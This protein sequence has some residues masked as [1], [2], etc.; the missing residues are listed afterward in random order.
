MFVSYVDMGFHL[1]QLIWN[2]SRN[3]ENSLYKHL[4][5]RMRL[6]NI[7]LNNHVIIIV[8]CMHYEELLPFLRKVMEVLVCHSV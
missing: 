1:L 7:D 8:H 5:K 2:V 6:F 4:Q 3:T